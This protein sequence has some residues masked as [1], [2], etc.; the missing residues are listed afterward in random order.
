MDYKWC[1]IKDYEKSSP[2]LNAISVVD[3][4]ENA[5]EY[6]ND[7]EED[8]KTSSPTPSTKSKTRHSPKDRERLDRTTL[9]TNCPVGVGE[10]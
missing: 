5:S 1:S 4:E 7:Y 3:L 8:P 9:L 2:G 6:Q 10:R